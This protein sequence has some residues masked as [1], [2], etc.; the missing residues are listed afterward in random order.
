MI[1]HAADPATGKKDGLSRCPCMYEKIIKQALPALYHQARLSDFS[2]GQSAAIELWMEQPGSGLFLSGATGTGKT[3]LACAIFRH[4]IEHKRPAR[5]KRAAQYY[6]EVRATYR[7]EN[8]D[9]SEEAVISALADCPFLVLDDFGSG[10]F[11]D[12]ERRCTLELLDRRINGKLPTLITSNWTVTQITEK[13][14]EERIGSRLSTF[15]Q[16]I[17]EGK[18]RRLG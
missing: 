10:S 9:E 4:R 14:N 12:H 5:F 2:A 7:D 8:R 16:M 11:S 13:M 15:R 6:L 1:Y 18:D 3:H 17:F